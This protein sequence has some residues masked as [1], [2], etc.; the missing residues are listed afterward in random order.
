MMEL[1]MSSFHFKKL[2]FENG[3]SNLRNRVSRIGHEW[4]TFGVYPRFDF[5]K[6]DFRLPIK[7]R[8]L[9]NSKE[10]KDLVGQ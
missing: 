10:W 6:G 9:G 8:L 4:I 7:N 1:R 5:R 2:T 3:V